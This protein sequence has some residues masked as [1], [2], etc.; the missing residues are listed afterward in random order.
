[1]LAVY[2]IFRKDEC[3]PE[4]DEKY[5][6]FFRYFLAGMHEIWNDYR[7]SDHEYSRD[8]DYFLREIERRYDRYDSYDD[9]RICENGS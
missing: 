5:S 9:S 3:Q 2:K 4:D 7:G 8:I 1:M 6:F